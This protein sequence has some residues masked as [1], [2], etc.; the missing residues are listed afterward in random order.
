MSTVTEEIKGA[1]TKNS[2]NAHPNN[3]ELKASPERLGAALP[4]KRNSAI[5]IKNQRQGSDLS[6]GQKQQ[7]LQN[8]LNATF[9]SVINLF[10]KNPT[11]HTTNKPMEKT[12][13]HATFL[14]VQNLFQ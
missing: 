11:L 2:V 8:T 1:D 9:L 14:G 10:Q 12:N 7:K 5:S 6:E 4:E 3:P 13:L